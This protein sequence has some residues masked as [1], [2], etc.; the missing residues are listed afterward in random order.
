[1][2]PTFLPV[3]LILKIL[4]SFACLSVD[5]AQTVCLIAT[6]TLPTGLAT[7]YRVVSIKSNRTLNKFM[8]SIA[9]PDSEEDA[10]WIGQLHKRAGLHVRSL[11]NT[12]AYKYELMSCIGKCPNLEN[13]ALRGVQIQ[14][15][16]TLIER[17][18]SYGQEVDERLFLP[19]VKRITILEG[20]F[21]RIFPRCLD[22]DRFLCNLTHLTLMDTN[23][24]LPSHF[25]D[26]R[27]QALTHVTMPIQGNLGHAPRDFSNLFDRSCGSLLSHPGMRLKMIVLRIA[28]QELAKVVRD[29]RQRDWVDVPFVQDLVLDANWKDPRLFVVPF[30]LFQA[31]TFRSWEREA[32]GEGS[33]WDEAVTL[34]QRAKGVRRRARRSMEI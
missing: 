19:G 24:N 9:T 15:L 31:N 27:L 23:L 11:L 4:A 34:L 29:W 14:S 33:I 30:N 3:E 13:L 17:S 16:T 26:Q 22:T 6:W 21:L 12:C 18:Y 8:D 7:L 25:P 1:M 10:A 32:R 20:G 2:E 28:E 5:S